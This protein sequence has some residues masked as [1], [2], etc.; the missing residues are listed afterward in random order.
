MLQPTQIIITTHYIEEARQAD[1]IGLMRHGRLL[2]EANPDR[3]LQQF[4]LTTIEDVFLK[5]CM[6][7]DST[8]KIVR[9]EMKESQTIDDGMQLRIDNANENR[10]QFA[11]FQPTKAGNYHFRWRRVKAIMSDTY[12][13]MQ[14]KWLIT[15]FTCILPTIQITLFHLSIGRPPNLVPITIAT[16]ENR[17]SQLSHL[18]IDSL[19][20]DINVVSLNWFQN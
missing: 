12:R 10:I 2:A 4:R 1:S 8:P 14:S 11:K 5:L 3:L 17:T 18:F 9:P 13:L 6:K 7:E 15:L 19:A 20:T 16:S